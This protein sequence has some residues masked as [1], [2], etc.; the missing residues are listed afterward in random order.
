M[1]QNCTF[2]QINESKENDF[3]KYFLHNYLYSIE[4]F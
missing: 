4:R 2:Y 1:T 3:T